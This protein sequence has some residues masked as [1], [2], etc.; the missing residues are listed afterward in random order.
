M[1]LL[2]VLCLLWAIVKI[3]ALM[4]RYVTQSRAERGR[5]RSCGSCSCSSSPAG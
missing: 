5:A 1:N 2:I 3:P 4:R